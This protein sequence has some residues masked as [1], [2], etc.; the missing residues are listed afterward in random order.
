MTNYFLKDF[1]DVKNKFL[2]TFKLNNP[3]ITFGHAS[4]D[5]ISNFLLAEKMRVVSCDVKMV[6]IALGEN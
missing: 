3:R 4:Y 2:S 1:F 6:A 5:S